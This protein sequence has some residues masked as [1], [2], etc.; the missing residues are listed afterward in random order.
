MDR[1]PARLYLESHD[2]MHPRP[3]RDASGTPMHGALE[4]ECRACGRVIRSGLDFTPSWSLLARI[5]RQVGWARERSR[6]IA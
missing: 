2:L 1:C 4:Q 5:R 6:R 3:V